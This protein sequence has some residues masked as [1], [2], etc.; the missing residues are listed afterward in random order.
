[1]RLFTNSGLLLAAL[2]VGFLYAWHSIPALAG[3][4]PEL[5]M[6]QNELLFVGVFVMLLVLL[7]SKRGKDD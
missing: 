5:F 3:A 7:I 1:M 2:A 6:F 4:I